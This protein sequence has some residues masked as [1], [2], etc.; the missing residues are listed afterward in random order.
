M[1]VYFFVIFGTMSLFALLYFAAAVWLARNHPQREEQLFNTVLELLKLNTIRLPDFPRLLG[2]FRGQNSDG[3]ANVDPRSP[4]QLPAPPISG[5]N[6]TQE[7][8]GQVEN[9]PAPALS[10][11]GS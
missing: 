6:L 10:E 9:P 1:Q 5:P 8:P 3:K 2:V 4:P 7:D 11:I